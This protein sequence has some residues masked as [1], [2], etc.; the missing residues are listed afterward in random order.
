MA[1]QAA[2]LD[3]AL[4]S[5]LRAALPEQIGDDL[6]LRLADGR[7]FYI[8]GF[9][10]PDEVGNGQPPLPEAIELAPDIALILL[11][12]SDIDTAAGGEAPVLPPDSS[13]F[14]AFAPNPPTRRGDPVS[15]DSTTGNEDDDTSSDGVLG[16][17]NR[18]RDPGDE[19]RGLGGGSIGGIP[20]SS[21]AIGTISLAAGSLGAPTWSGP[22]DLR[23]LFR[24]EQL[25][26]PAFEGWFQNLSRAKPFS[27]PLD[28]ATFLSRFDP[29]QVAAG[30]ITRI[31]Y[32]K[33]LQLREDVVTFAD[34]R[35]L[36]A[37]VDSFANSQV[38]RDNSV[39]SGLPPG[40]TP[41]QV[42]AGDDFIVG[43]GWT[44]DRLYGFAGNDILIG[45]AGE[46]HLFGG[47]GNDLLISG[48]GLAPREISGGDGDD[49]L[50]LVID[51]M[52]VI[53]ASKLGPISSI[54]RIVLMP[55]NE[56]NPTFLGDDN[57]SGR[58]ILG[59]LV[60]AID[61]ATILAW[62]GTLAIDNDA[63]DVRLTDIEAWTRL[64][65]G[66]GDPAYIHYQAQVGGQTVSLSIL[67]TAD[68]PIAG[69]VVG[70]GG[71]D[72]F[73]LGGRT[74]GSFDGAGGTDQIQGSLAGGPIGVLDL[75][76]AATVPFRNIESILQLASSDQVILS[77][78]SIAAM[79][80]ARNTLWLTGAGVGTGADVSFSYRT[81]AA[82]GQAD[83]V[84]P[85]AWTALGYLSIETVGQPGPE[86]RIGAIYGA[87]IGAENVYLFV[88][89][90]ID[91]PLVASATTIDHWFVNHGGWVYLP[92]DGI[93]LDLA[94]ID[95]G[96][97][98]G[99]FLML[100]V[101]GL[102]AIAGADGRV[103][104]IGD[105]GS[106]IVQFGDMTRWRFSHVESG[107]S[108][109]LGDDG[110]GHQVELHVATD[111]GQPDLLP[112]TATGDLDILSLGNGH[113]NLLALDVSSARE[114]AG[115][116]GQMRIY[117][118]APGDK[119]TFSDPENWTLLY[120]DGNVLMYEGD[121]GS[122]A[123]R[124]GIQADLDLPV[125]TPAASDGDDSLAVTRLQ[126][127][128]QVA[129]I[130]GKGGFDTLQLLDAGDI[131]PR[132]DSILNFEAIDLANGVANRLTINAAMV[133]ANNDAGPLLITGDAGDSVALSPAS[134]ASS[135]YAWFDTGTEITHPEFAG[136]TF[137]VYQAQVPTNGFD[138]IVQVAIDQALTQ[139][140]LI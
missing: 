26:D 87:T 30:A 103:A 56:N 46:N 20:L 83:L 50:M 125:L 105:P 135:N 119:I 21:S 33:Y 34:G 115:P 4:L 60:F 10:A 128:E 3:P 36:W 17:D 104:V 88:Q 96:N 97:G 77:A 29:A 69:D 65:P 15:S 58:I 94:T 107:F 47:D 85:T 89:L 63:A 81:G 99:N 123:V 86:T 108:V 41:E 132:S 68:Q 122:G 92:A 31:D 113:A 53:D 38:T 112:D 90:G 139:P 72:I 35:A 42:F 32:E 52:S 138:V 22:Y 70:T 28:A 6:V 54:E 49:T 44:I 82:K 40:V 71:D 2:D 80:D 84:D 8:D 134:L 48:L 24:V 37:C 1:L 98:L 140:D 93:Q 73:Y 14:A 74:F 11:G 111:I 39:S 118:D 130:D 45:F 67:A 61:A 131:F 43:A 110:A 13:A 95:L 100:D 27:D 124:I 129:P 78:E 64:P 116:D 136:K 51:L 137:V 75:H 55:Q 102:A 79:T 57:D 76:D 16:Q 12:E 127:L 7:V 109:Y 62:G 5:L 117:G 114:L 23:Y 18:S 91:L 120:R 106:D 126:Y 19:S 66:Q 9:F 101:A 59:N 25:V 133:A 121:D